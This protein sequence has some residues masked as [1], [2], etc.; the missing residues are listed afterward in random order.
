MYDVSRTQK[1]TTPQRRNTQAAGGTSALQRR[2]DVSE[3]VTALADLQNR[4]DAKGGTIQRYQDLHALYADMPETESKT[5]WLKRFSIAQ[6]MLNTPA[7]VNDSLEFLSREMLKNDQTLQQTLNAAML[8]KWGEQD[9]VMTGF[10]PQQTFLAIIRDGKLFRDYVGQRHGV[11]SHQIQWFTLQRFLGAD[12]AIALYKEAGN[13]RWRVGN[14]YMWDHIVD[15][16]RAQEIDE[17]DFT[18]PENLETYLY[19]QFQGDA[20]TALTREANTQHDERGDNVAALKDRYPA[21]SEFTPPLTDAIPILSDW[22]QRRIHGATLMGIHDEV[23]TNTTGWFWNQKTIE[24]TGWI[25][26]AGNTPD[27]YFVPTVGRLIS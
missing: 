14:S 8:E 6:K 27:P 3:Q 15:V 20:S 1:Q 21:E 16:T 9:R 26:G 7:M 12:E 13:P 23:V 25:K 24:W 2:A 19:T 5:E 22:D 11:H 4:A 17:N 10:V 18:V